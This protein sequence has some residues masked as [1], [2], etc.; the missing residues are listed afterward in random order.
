[1]MTDLTLSQRFFLCTAPGT[2][3]VDVS[4][5]KGAF[6]LVAA[7]LLEL[8][9]AGCVAI[10]EEMVRTCAPLPDACAPLAPLYA[11]LQRKGPMNVRKLARATALKNMLLQPLTG[12]TLITQ[13]AQ[14]VGAALAAQ[15]LA[16]EVPQKRGGKKAFFQPRVAAMAAEIARLQAVL[17]EQ[18]Q[19]LDAATATLALL[20]DKL[21]ILARHFGEAERRQMRA[22]LDEAAQREEN[23]AVLQAMKHFEDLCRLNTALSFLP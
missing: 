14:R 23:A 2:A 12:D 22:V 1:M 11:H 4:D 21:D 8:E 17:V 5:D 19:P 10:D 3:S 6:G 13:L 7:A 16:Q 15:D 9:L 20:L 18:T